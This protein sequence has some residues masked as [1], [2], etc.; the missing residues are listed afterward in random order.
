M[1]KYTQRELHNEAFRNMLK[2]AFRVAGKGILGAAKNVAKHISPELYG[3]AKSA[4]EIYNSGD[5]NAVLKEYLLKTRAVPIFLKSPARGAAVTEQEIIDGS[6][7]PTF[8]DTYVP[9]P[10]DTTK[11]IVVKPNSTKARLE[12]VKIGRIINKNDGIIAIPFTAKSG[13]YVA[14][15]DKIDKDK[16]QIIGIR[17]E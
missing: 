4:K 13:D 7:D 2:G 12:L 9:D 14:Y 11:R 15:I 6:A 10:G 3:M 8:R 17:E 16:Q 1:R 5:P